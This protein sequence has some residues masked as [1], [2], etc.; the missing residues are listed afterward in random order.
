MKVD[1]AATGVWSVIAG[2]F[3]TIRLLIGIAILGA[4]GFG[5]LKGCTPGTSSKST[6]STTG[7]AY[8]VAAAGLNCRVDADPAS[9]V[10]EQLIHDAQIDVLETRD[11][12]ARV[13]QTSGDC[14]VKLSKLQPVAPPQPPPPQLSQL[15]APQLGSAAKPAFR[16]KLTAAPMLH[17]SP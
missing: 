3:H 6:A 2:I 13:H 1:E 5:V 12:W 15:Q 14:W 17:R 10:R 16:L 8:T 9:A 7:N 11:G 4:I